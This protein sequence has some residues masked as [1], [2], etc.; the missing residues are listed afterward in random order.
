[1]KRQRT[2]S[3]IALIIAITS[4][5]I[6]IISIILNCTKVV[7]NNII[8]LVALVS[9]LAS[10]EFFIVSIAAFVTFKHYERNAQKSKEKS[11]EKIKL[12]LSNEFSE[13]KLKDPEI[14]TLIDGV[15]NKAIKVMAK[16]DENDKI[17]FTIQVDAQI[18]TDSYKWFL[19]YFDV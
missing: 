1:M 3:E 12:K 10:A 6:L 5:I 18:R 19:D 17:I 8:K 11:F 7:E 15:P 9:I 13:V 2:N 4:A 16:L 14:S